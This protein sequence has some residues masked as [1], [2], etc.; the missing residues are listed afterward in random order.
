MPPK[1]A[2]RWSADGVAGGAQRLLHLANL[3]LTEVEHAGREH[4]VGA[5]GDRRGEIPD[6]AGATARDHRDVHD[7]AHRLDQLQV[8]PALCA[9]GVHGVQ[10]DLAGA[11]FGCPAR[12]DDRVKAG[13]SP[14][15]VRGHLEPAPARSSAARTPPETF[16][17]AARTPPEASALAPRTPAREQR[18]ARVHRHHHALRT[19]PPTV[20]G[21]N[22]WSA[23]RA[24]TST[25]VS[26][27]SADAV[28][29][30]NTS[31][32]APSA[33]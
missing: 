29:S 5:R 4:R 6:P 8:E 32:S 18:A 17:S 2:D 31:S 11:E 28:M 9:V 20:S 25:I 22:T 13:A 24:T 21:M 1:P 16:T 23:V 7:F 3:D 26:R 30:R 12:P 19:P 10:Q 15:A 27:C 14:A 33:S